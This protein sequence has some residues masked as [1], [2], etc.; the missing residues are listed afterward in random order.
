MDSNKRQKIE[1]KTKYC[2]LYNTSSHD[3][4]E[5]KIMLKKTEQIRLGYDP[6][7]H[8]KGPRKDYRDGYNKK[9][10]LYIIIEK[11]VNKKIPKQK[12]NK[13]N[14]HFEKCETEIETKEFNIFITLIIADSDSEI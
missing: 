5:C 10:N 1:T 12:K 6:I 2:L 14:V 7:N 9:E 4:S 11:I 13:K 8:K 3:I